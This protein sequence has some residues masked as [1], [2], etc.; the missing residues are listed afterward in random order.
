MTISWEAIAAISGV[1]VLIAGGS[2][3]AVLK[4]YGSQRQ[5]ADNVGDKLTEITSC[6][7]GEQGST[8]EKISAID[9]KLDS[10][11]TRHDQLCPMQNGTIKNIYHKLSVIQISVARLEEHR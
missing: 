7:R 9:K 2:F 10:F 1:L 5:T 11:M 3:G 4:I 6:V 8:R